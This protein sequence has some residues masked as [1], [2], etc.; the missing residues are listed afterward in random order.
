MVRQDADSLQ[1]SPEVFDDI[2]EFRVTL[3]LLGLF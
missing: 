1:F 3:A 2:D